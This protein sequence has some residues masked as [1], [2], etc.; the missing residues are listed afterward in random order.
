MFPDPVPTRRAAVLLCNGSNV[1]ALNPDAIN[2]IFTTVARVGAWTSRWQPCEDKWRG[3]SYR[4]SVWCNA[5]RS[6][7]APCAPLL[8]IF[9]TGDPTTILFTRAIRTP[10][11]II[12]GVVTTGAT[13]TDSRTWCPGIMEMSI[14]TRK[15]ARCQFCICTVPYLLSKVRM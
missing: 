5:V 13:T 10:Y 1:S 4:S 12:I 8:S 14:G 11:I 9:L 7:R 15:C 2:Y 6:P 3:I